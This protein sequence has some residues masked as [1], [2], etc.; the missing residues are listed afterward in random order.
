MQP[1]PFTGW[2]IVPLL[3]VGPP[4]LVALGVYAW[5]HSEDRERFAAGLG[6][7]FSPAGRRQAAAI[8]IGLALAAFVAGVV[9]AVGS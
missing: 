8:M 3:V 1:I 7:G 6:S 2:L 4:I 5:R 9:R